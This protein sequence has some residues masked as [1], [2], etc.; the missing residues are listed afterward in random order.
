MHDA[1]VICYHMHAINEHMD[2]FVSVFRNGLQAIKK[3]YEIPRTA[4]PLPYP[5]K[6][7]KWSTR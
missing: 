7:K 3:A 4:K 6:R 1:H 5:K 2:E